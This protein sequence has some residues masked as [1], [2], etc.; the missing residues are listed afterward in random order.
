MKIIKKNPRIFWLDQNMKNDV[1]S[2]EMFCNKISENPRF[3][4]Y[5]FQRHSLLTA[6][7]GK[8]LRI[9]TMHFLVL[10]FKHCSLE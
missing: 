5:N 1:N 8:N 7:R 2:Q 6:L 10:V 4:L 3:F 9:R